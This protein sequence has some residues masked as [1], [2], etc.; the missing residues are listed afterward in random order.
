G[1]LEFVRPAGVPAG[2]VSQSTNQA[3]PVGDVLTAQFD[4]GNSS[5]VRK[6]VTVLLHD[7]DFT[8]LASCTFWLEPGAPLG[9]HVIR[10][11]T[12]EP[13]TNASVSFYPAAVGLEQWTRLDNV[14]FRRTPTVNPL[15]TE[16]LEPGSSPDA[17]LIAAT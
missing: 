13:W 9:T 4:L 16:C 15:G 14:V 8:D 17:P 6:R 7:S 1:V 10:M 5:A 2:V 11:F 12:T 3:L